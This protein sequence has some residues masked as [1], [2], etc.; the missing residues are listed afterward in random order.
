MRNR[1]RP[2]GTAQNPMSSRPKAAP[3]VHIAA[4]HV[5]VTEWRFKPGAETG[6]R[7]YEA[8]YVVVPPGTGLAVSRGRSR[9][10][11]RSL[12]SQ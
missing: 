1:S 12:A 10:I 9:G 7:V 4:P 11:Q 2:S 5:R 6:W 8:D 3:H